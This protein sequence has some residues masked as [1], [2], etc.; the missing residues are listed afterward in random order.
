MN[1]TIVDAFHKLFYSSENTWRDTRWLGV[2][3][4]QNPLDMW[5]LQEIIHE[6]RPDVI[7][8]TGTAA[9]GSALFYVSI[10]GGKVISIDTQERLRPVFTHERIHFIKGF[11]TDVNIRE[12]V[13]TLVAGQRVMVI[14]D[15]DHTTE[16]V[17]RE[18]EL[19]APLVTLDC[20]L[21]VCDTNL[22]G[23]PIQNPEVPGAGPMGAV[24]DY[25]DTHVDFRVDHECEKFYLTFFP[26]GWLR[27]VR[28]SG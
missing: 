15:S 11:S 21:V 4:Y 26:G 22:G 23:N 10:F 19:Y 14:L 1:Q 27:R 17:A 5:V 16:N 8:E 2:P 18:M 28:W 3:V 25:L 9:G 24:Q 12:Q 6:T 20:Y 13:C 7:I